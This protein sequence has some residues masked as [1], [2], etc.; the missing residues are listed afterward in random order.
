VTAAL[1]DV[2]VASNHC[3]H[4]LAVLHDHLSGRRNLTPA[5]WD[6]L[7]FQAWLQNQR[8]AQSVAA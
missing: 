7:M 8:G 3:K 4:T 2:K 6:L 1:R 5:I